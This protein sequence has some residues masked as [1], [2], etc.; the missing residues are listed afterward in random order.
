VLF[1]SSHLGYIHIFYLHEFAFYI[2]LIS[3]YSLLSALTR[4]V[5]SEMTKSPKKPR[6][7]AAGQE[8]VSSSAR[9]GNGMLCFDIIP[10]SSRDVV[11]EAMKEVDVADALVLLQEPHGKDT[12]SDSL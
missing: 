10:R 3:L 12:S 6:Q 2:F 1:I 9:D 4:S 11:K 7:N 8:E 5:V